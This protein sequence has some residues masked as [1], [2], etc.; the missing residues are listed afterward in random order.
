MDDPITKMFER[1]ALDYQGALHT[2]TMQQNNSGPL[3]LAFHPTCFMICAQF[4]TFRALVK[5]TRDVA[6]GP[7]EYCG[8]GRMVKD[9]HGRSILTVTWSDVG[10]LLS[11]LLH[12]EARGLQ[13][14][15]K[16]LDKPGLSKKAI[17]LKQKQKLNEDVNTLLRNCDHSSPPTC[18]PEQTVPPVKRRRISQDKYIAAQD[19]LQI[20]EDDAAAVTISASTVNAPAISRVQFVCSAQDERSSVPSDSTKHHSILGSRLLCDAWCYAQLGALS[21]NGTFGY[22][23]GV[24]VTSVKILDVDQSPKREELR[25]HGCFSLMWINACAGLLDVHRTLSEGSVG[26]AMQHP[27]RN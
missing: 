6:I 21:M 15:M 14:H 10:S 3:H 22:I 8:T 12:R 27:E 17:S 4:G 2:H 19:I 26:R 1:R 25:A 11:S 24:N 20:E 7:L 13:R 16:G 5:N 18:K 9:N 23:L